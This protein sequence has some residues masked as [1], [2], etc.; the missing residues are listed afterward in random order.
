MP[1]TKRQHYVTRAYLEGFLSP[2]ESLLHC[3]GRGRSS[4]FRALP[5]NLAH[6]RDFYSFKDAAGSWDDSAEELLGQ[7]IEAPGLSILRKLTTGKFNLSNEERSKLSVLIAAQE[8]RTPFAREAILK[9][10]EGFSQSLIAGYERIPL[11]SRLST[12]KFE[13][14]GIAHEI[15]MEEVYAAHTQSLE[16]KERRSVFLFLDGAMH[17]SKLYQHMKWTVFVSPDSNEFVTT[18]CPVIRVYYRGGGGPAGLNRSDLEVRFP[19]SRKMMLAITHD[20]P[21][22]KKLLKA[23]EKDRAAVLARRKEIRQSFLSHAEVEVLNRDHV[24]HAQRWVFS[25]HSLPWAIEDLATT[26]M[27][28]KS[29]Y[30]EQGQLAGT[31]NVVQYDP[32]THIRFR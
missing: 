19:L 7:Q 29:L 9:S 11:E 10:Q 1:R 23:K 12:I 30:I 24:A 8:M 5:I 17:I 28:T 2:G 26:S 6:Q 21:F 20:I 25:G 4:V 31:R 16:E 14:Q 32:N 18:D 3:Y 15:P 13:Q 22:A 27:N